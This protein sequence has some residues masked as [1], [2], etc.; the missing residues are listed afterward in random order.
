MS[1]DTTPS[2]DTAAPRRALIVRNPRARRVPAELRV[3]EAA[4]PLVARGWHIDLRNT[5]APEHAVELA[6]EA[7]RDGADVVVAC[8]GDGTV[9]EVVNGLVGTETALSVLPG[10]T[11]NIW[12]HEAGV[13]RN[14][15]R[16]LAL[17]T[18]GRRERVDLGIIEWPDGR[19]ARHFLLMCGVGLDAEVV[20]RV[21][22]GGWWKRRLGRAWYIVVGLSTALRFAPVFAEIEAGGERFERELLLGIAGNTRHYGGRARLTG[23]ALIDDGQ[24]DLCLFSGR[25]LMSRARLA[26]RALR[27]G[28]DR[29]TGDGIDYL[30]SSEIALTPRRAL[31]LQADGEYV[32]E[33]PVRL[34]AVPRALTVVLAPRPNVLIGADGAHDS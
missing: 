8:G 24:L 12:A 10:G 30:R 17:L 4:R 23:A 5:E 32:G 2:F 25:S 3:M 7:A 1:A 31:P 34:R 20:R 9:H 13:P 28:L 14:P 26:A 27:G 18:D 22:S 29:R 16:A 21:G 15:E 33:T 19:P 11:A 6:A